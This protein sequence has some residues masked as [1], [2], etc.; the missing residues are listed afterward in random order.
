[1]TG[2]LAMGTNDIIFS[3][4]MLRRADANYINIMNSLGT[5][6]RRLRC[7][8]VY[9]NFLRGHANTLDFYTHTNAIAEASFYSYTGA[10][11]V[12]NIKLMGGNVFMENLPVADP[13]IVGV[14]WNNGG[15]LTVSAG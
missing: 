5:Q 13:H 7:F 4:I 11:Y 10:A 15:V 9:T 3:D 12:K 2:D 1:M 8:A 6:Y 14:L